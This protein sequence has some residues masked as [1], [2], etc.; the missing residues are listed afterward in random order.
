[1]VPSDASEHYDS[2]FYYS[3]DLYAAELLQSPTYSEDIKRKLKLLA[4]E[5]IHKSG[6]WL[7]EAG[8]EE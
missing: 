4:N 7:S 1:M 8:P 6:Y 2:E 3:D 5:A